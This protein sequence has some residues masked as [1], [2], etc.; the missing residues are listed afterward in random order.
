MSK[1]NK[2]HT[3]KDIVRINGV[4]YAEEFP[5]SGRVDLVGTDAYYDLGEFYDAVAKKHGVDTDDIETYMMDNIEFDPDVMPYG[6]ESCG[7][8]IDSVAEWLIED[9]SGKVD[10]LYE[11]ML[12]EFYDYKNSLLKLSPSEL[13]G[14]FA[15][16]EL[17]YKEDLLLCF[18]EDD[19]LLLSEDDVAFL[20]K[21]DTPLDW[22][23]KSWC[24]SGISH[25]DMLRAFIEEEVHRKRYSE[26]QL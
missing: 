1:N 24:D 10:L 3:W 9:Y 4:N 14:G 23:F 16:Y 19:D 25:M 5:I 22:L 8:Y 13:I 17:V 18:E 20:L 21:M 12:Q 6:A 11:K 26:T 15:A 7:C 2:K